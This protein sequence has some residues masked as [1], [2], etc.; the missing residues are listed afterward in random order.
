MGAPVFRHLGEEV[1]ELDPERRGGAVNT[2]RAVLQVKAEDKKEGE[3]MT[4]LGTPAAC[5]AEVG[6]RHRV[7]GI[8][9]QK[10]Q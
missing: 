5:M 1:L 3:G 8:I 4:H 2:G 10:A 7:F 6:D 9:Q